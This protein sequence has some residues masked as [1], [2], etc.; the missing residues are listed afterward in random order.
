MNLTPIFATNIVNIMEAKFKSLSI[1][2]FQSKF[3]DEDSCYAY[4]SELKWKGGYECPK[5]KHKSVQEAH[6]QIRS[7]MLNVDI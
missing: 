6:Q 2:E 1:F 4:L 5:C 7:A 3:P